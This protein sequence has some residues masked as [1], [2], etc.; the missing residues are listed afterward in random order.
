MDD[1]RISTGNRKRLIV[2]NKR[3]DA[4]VVKGKDTECEEVHIKSE[5][6]KILDIGGK[7]RLTEG[8]WPL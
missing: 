8:T 3:C 6:F 2:R 5:V 1:S 4:V 7:R